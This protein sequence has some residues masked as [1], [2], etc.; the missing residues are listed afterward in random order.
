MHHLAFEADESF[1]AELEIF[2]KIR[3]QLAE[4][5]GATPDAAVCKWYRLRPVVA[6]HMRNSRL[7]V[8]VIH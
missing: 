6:G 1:E 5:C 8:E 3:K 7:D 4:A 2:R